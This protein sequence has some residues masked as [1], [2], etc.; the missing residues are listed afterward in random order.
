MTIE[1]RLFASL[2]TH[3]PPGSPRGK[4]VLDVPAGTSVGAV[5]T[6]MHIPFASAHLLLVNG[7]HDRDFDRV[8]G[9][10]DVLSVFPPVA[11]G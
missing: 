8:L 10:G 11:G 2:R 7:E 1:L 9:D 3:L 4:C 5:L 6:R